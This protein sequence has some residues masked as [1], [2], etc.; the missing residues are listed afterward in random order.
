MHLISI[1]LQLSYIPVIYVC[2]MTSLRVD[3]H[4]SFD[5]GHGK[6]QTAGSLQQRQS[7]FIECEIG[8]VI[9]LDGQCIQP[10]QIAAQTILFAETF[11]VYL[12]QLV[13]CN[14]SRGAERNQTF[15][16]P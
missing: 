3:Q 14:V 9:T 8:T 6:C 2:F 12:R 5:R 15:R 10:L 7:V 11:K 16:I 4:L 1:F 13:C